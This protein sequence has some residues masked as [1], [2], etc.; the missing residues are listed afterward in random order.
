MCN[1]DNLAPWALQGEVGNNGKRGKL[2]LSVS[3]KKS[4]MPV[5]LQTHAGSLPLLTHCKAQAA[6][7][8]QL[9]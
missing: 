2:K 4:S 1:K 3:F 7:S 8:E 6:F 5:V 9:H